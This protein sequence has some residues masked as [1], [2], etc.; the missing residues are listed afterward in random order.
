MKTHTILLI[1]FVALFF[2][3]CDD[4]NVSSVSCPKG[5]LATVKD[6]AGLD[7]CGFIFELT[8]G[9][10]LEPMRMMFCGTPPLPKEI[11]E[12][13]LYNFQ[14]IDGKQVRIGYEEMTD[15]ASICMVGKIVRITCL[16]EINSVE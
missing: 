3:S 2:L 1:F 9:T 6:L 10:R 5:E 8:D 14:F 13:P 4:E 12:D 16:E 7:G 15:A 11:T